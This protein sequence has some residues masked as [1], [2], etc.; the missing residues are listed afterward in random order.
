MNIFLI[1]NYVMAKTITFFFQIEFLYLY[2][3]KIPN[4]V[5]KANSFKDKTVMFLTFKLCEDSF[6][7]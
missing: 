2:R 1:K 7:I 6:I 3:V 4:S 5:I